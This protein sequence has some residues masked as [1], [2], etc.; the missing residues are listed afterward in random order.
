MKRFFNLLPPLHQL[1]SGSFGDWDYDCL[2]WQTKSCYVQVLLGAW[3]EL[4]ISHVRGKRCLPTIFPKSIWDTQLKHSPGPFDGRSYGWWI[5]IPFSQSLKSNVVHFAVCSLEPLR[6]SPASAVN[7][8]KQVYLIWFS[9]GGHPLSSPGIRWFYH[10]FVP[11]F[12][13]FHQKY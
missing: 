5:S 6:T 7:P 10:I 4:M 11:H 1:S 13:S 12:F 2:R 8:L 3:N 9:V